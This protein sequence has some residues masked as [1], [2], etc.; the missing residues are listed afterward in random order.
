MGASVSGEDNAGAPGVRLG[1][2]VP[3]ALPLTSALMGVNVF[4]WWRMP[5]TL[6][7]ML[8]PAEIRGAS[9]PAGVRDGVIGGLLL[10]I[11]AF[12]VHW[13]DI[14]VARPPS[15]SDFTREQTA[16]VATGA[17]LRE[18]TA[19]PR[20]KIVTTEKTAATLCEKTAAAPREKTAVAPCE[21]LAATLREKTAIALHEKSAG[22]PCGFEKT[23]PAP[24]SLEKTPSGS[25]ES[26]PERT[27]PSGA[28]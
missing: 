10:V 14:A 4:P 21:K 22:A 6:G 15:G 17:A 7:S 23:S 12:Q 27:G 19:A 3:R 13:R 2:A 11:L 5:G 9:S 16:P 18:K 1:Q 28:S 25:S 20:E 26:R 24:R 8:S